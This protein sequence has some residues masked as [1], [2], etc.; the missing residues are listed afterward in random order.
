MV[1]YILNKEDKVTE[2]QLREVEEAKK[3][4]I[5]YDEDSPKLSPAMMKAFQC[6]AERRHRKNA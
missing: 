4:P 5:V 1:E 6:V 3:S 2:E